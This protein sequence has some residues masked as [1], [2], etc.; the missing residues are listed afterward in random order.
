[1]I[2]V[3]KLLILINQNDKLLSSYKEATKLMKHMCWY[4]YAHRI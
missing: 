1:M 2:K 4:R 3:D